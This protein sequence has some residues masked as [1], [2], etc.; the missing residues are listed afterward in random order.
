MVLFA[1]KVKAF[2]FGPV[3]LDHRSFNTREARRQEVTPNEE[4]HAQGD[5]SG[6]VQ[7]L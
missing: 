2:Q 4:R 6:T 3:S 1:Y 5:I 7:E